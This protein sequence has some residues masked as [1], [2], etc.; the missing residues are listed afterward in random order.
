MTN[1]C[2]PWT[3]YDVTINSS[4]FLIVNIVLMKNF[5]R[6]FPLIRESS[7]LCGGKSFRKSRKYNYCSSERSR[8]VVILVVEMLQNVSQPQKLID[9]RVIP[10]IY[11]QIRVIQKNDI[12]NQQVY[13]TLC[14][15]V[16]HVC[17][18]HIILLSSNKMLS[19]RITG[20]S[21]SFITRMLYE[22]YE[23]WISSFCI[24]TTTTKKTHQVRLC[25]CL[26][27]VWIRHSIPWLPSAMAWYS[28]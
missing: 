15:Y 10:K 17:T 21:H 19:N 9:N 11:L 20:I 6:I 3:K 23:L 8:W 18:M 1:C 28:F 12:D 5:Q 16:L 14:V 24:R 26:Y 4:F 27:G 25:C 22:K 13:P 7:L 2:V